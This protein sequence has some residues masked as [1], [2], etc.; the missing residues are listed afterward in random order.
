MTVKTK[1]NYA[2]SPMSYGPV[3]AIGWGYVHPPMLQV[4]IPEEVNTT[5][6]NT[7]DVAH[8]AGLSMKVCLPVNYDKW[9]SWNKDTNQV[10]PPA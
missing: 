9:T 3:G 6:P 5:A 4:T 1:P 7:W 8:T 2:V 10:G